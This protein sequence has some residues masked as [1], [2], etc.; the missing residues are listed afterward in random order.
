MKKLSILILLLMILALTGCSQLGSTQTPTT[1]PTSQPE[2]TADTATDA[3]T[4]EPTTEP[5]S[6]AQ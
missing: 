4:S 6:A 2:E 3:P 5:T 1:A